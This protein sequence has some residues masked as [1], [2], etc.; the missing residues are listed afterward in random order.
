MTRTAV[1][2]GG[3]TGIGRAIAR[4]L[5]DQ[6]LDVVITGRRREVLADTAR[7]LGERVSAVAFDATD[8][9]QV[10]AAL[11]DLPDRVDVLVNNAGGLAKGRSDDLAAL[12]EQW[13]ADFESN[14]VSAVLVTTALEPRLADDGRVI[15]IGSIA[16][17]RDG[18]SYGAAKAS[19]EAW[20]ADLAFALGPR[21]I[22]A[23]VVS[24]GLI[25]DTEF[26]GGA[27]AEERRRRLIAQTATGRAGRP[28]DVAALVG[29]L[30]SPAAGHITGQVLPVNGGAH[31]A[32]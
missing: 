12:R 24:P 16:G 9:A 6:G 11:A 20:T 15:T 31:L 25:V 1:L 28:E 27:L 29:F 18:G 13:L 32:R 10:S 4:T 22:T 21:G 19:V 2:T 17:H 3:G 23:N 30:A 7:A 14:V 8:P 26:F 5:A